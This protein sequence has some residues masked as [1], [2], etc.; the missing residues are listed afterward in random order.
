M[1]YCSYVN[2]QKTMFRRELERDIK[3]CKKHLW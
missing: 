2:N 3:M 1:G